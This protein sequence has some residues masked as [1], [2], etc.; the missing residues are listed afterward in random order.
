LTLCPGGQLARRFIM[1]E[2]SVLINESK[3]DRKPPKDF[4]E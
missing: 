1:D 3:E 2:L 4:R